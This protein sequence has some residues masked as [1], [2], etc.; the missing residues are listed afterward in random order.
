MSKATRWPAPTGA[1]M[2]VVTSFPIPPGP[3]PFPV[4]Q[5]SIMASVG[6]TF[7][8][9]MGVAASNP[10]STN[11]IW[12]GSV[13]FRARRLVVF[14]HYTP[15]KIANSPYS[16]RVVETLAS[17]ADPI[18]VISWYFSEIH[19]VHAKLG[20]WCR[21]LRDKKVIKR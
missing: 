10:R 3:A 7:N 16:L 11:R 14:V 18:T 21:D 12:V 13:V 20:E 9:A 2:S 5:K 1:V 8:R 15:S 17:G 4:D 19:Q 6:L